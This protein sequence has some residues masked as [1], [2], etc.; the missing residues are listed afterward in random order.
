[1][2]LYIYIFFLNL[3]NKSRCRSLHRSDF[4][5]FS[6]SIPAPSDANN[7]GNSVYIVFSLLFITLKQIIHLTVLKSVQIIL[8]K[9]YQSR[10]CLQRSFSLKDDYT[11]FVFLQIK[12]SCPAELKDLR[13]SKKLSSGK[14][15]SYELQL[16]VPTI[17]TPVNKRE[18]LIVA[19]VPLSH[20]ITGQTTVVMPTHWHHAFQV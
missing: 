5:L 15:L 3:Y 11:E 10:F 9:K 18:D 12:C 14:T 20:F 7:P 19:E 13:A 17:H 8:Q 16:P 1:M 6:C 4:G 2:Y